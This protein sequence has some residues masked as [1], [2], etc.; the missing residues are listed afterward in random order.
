MII[1]LDI[2]THKVSMLFISTYLRS[3]IYSHRIPTRVSVYF[4][5]N[6]CGNFRA[7]F[8]E[9]V[10]FSTFTNTFFQDDEWSLILSRQNLFYDR[11]GFLRLAMHITQ[12][13]RCPA[14]TKL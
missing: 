2:R 9:A 3:I 1:V 13:R 7:I 10:S 11:L 5:L 12:F 4:P 14:A 8:S 6:L